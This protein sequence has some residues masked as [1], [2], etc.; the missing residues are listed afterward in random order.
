[1]SP[2]LSAIVEY[3]K[4]EVGSG[5]M[6]ASVCVCVCVCVH[7]CMHASPNLSAIV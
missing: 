4:K 5:Y 2:N 3:R 1:M 6:R 7:T